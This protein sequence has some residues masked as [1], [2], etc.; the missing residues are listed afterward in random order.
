MTMSQKSTV[1]ER[2]Q[3]AVCCVL[4][5]SWTLTFY[6]YDNL[7]AEAENRQI[8]NQITIVREATQGNEGWSLQIEQSDNH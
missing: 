2:G 8:R 4:S 3:A 6:F 5:S 1:S 7:V